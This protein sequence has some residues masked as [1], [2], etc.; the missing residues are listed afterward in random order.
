MAMGMTIAFAAFVTMPAYIVWQ[1][2]RDPIAR[3][4]W[5]LGWLVAHAVVVVQIALL[6]DLIISMVHL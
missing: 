3:D 2:W 1:G 6:L 5:A 4:E